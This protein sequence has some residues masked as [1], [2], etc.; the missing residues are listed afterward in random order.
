MK[1]HECYTRLSAERRRAQAAEDLIEKGADIDPQLLPVSCHLAV[2]LRAQTAVLP[3][4]IGFRIYKM[5]CH[6]Q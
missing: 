3:L 6:T 2:V 1:S 4:V 5:A